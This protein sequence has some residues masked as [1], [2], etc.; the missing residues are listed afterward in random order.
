MKRRSLRVTTDNDE[1]VGVSHSERDDTFT[2]AGSNG[3]DSEVSF[4]ERQSGILATWIANLQAKLQLTPGT[5][6]RSLRL[7][8]ENGDNFKVTH[9]TRTGSITLKGGDWEDNST[10]TLS[11]RQS[12][13]FIAWF[14]LVQAKTA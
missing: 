2:I 8:T 5:K 10:V 13:I 12:N 1:F 11:P 14:P 3:G 4:S 7:K 9:S 6:R